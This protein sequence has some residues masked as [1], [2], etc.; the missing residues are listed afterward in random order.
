MKIILASGSPRRKEL[1]EMFHLPQLQ[2]IPAKGKEQ[3]HP[4]LRPDE[5]VMELSRCKA[6]EI[7]AQ[8]AG[9]D[10]VVIGADTV[11]VWNGAV[12]GK[13]KDAADAKRMLQAL[14]GQVHTVFTGLTVIRG[15]R[16]LQHAERTEVHFR[17]LSGDEIAAYADTG[18]PLDKAGAYGYQGIAG[19]F[20]DRISGDYFN[21]VGLPICR[22]GQMLAQLGVKLL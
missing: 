5:L 14:S 8:Y 9:D 22:L 15:S 7:A 18:E 1:M 12:L 20:V 2:I 16:T 6:E 3:A 11:V 13:P 17:P 19:L 21:V 4:E 10:D